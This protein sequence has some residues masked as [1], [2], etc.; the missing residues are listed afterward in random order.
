MTRLRKIVL[1]LVAVFAI[2]LVASEISA[3][4]VV[5]SG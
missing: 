2:L 3:L 5:R 4:L 1:S